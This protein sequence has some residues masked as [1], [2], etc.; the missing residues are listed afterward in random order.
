[1]AGATRTGGQLAGRDTLVRLVVSALRIGFAPTP[2]NVLHW[3]SWAITLAVLLGLTAVLL[4]GRVYGWEVDVA[5]W[6][7]K[8]DYPQWAFTL[9]ADRL[10]NSDTPEGA[11][12]IASVAAVL[13]FLRLRI[14]AA[15]I[16][17]SVPLHILGNFPKVLVVR[18]RPSEAIDG[19]TGLTG[20][21]SFPSGHAEF[22]ITFYGFLVYVA[23]LHVRNPTLKAALLA[24]WVAMVLAVGFARIEVG[25]H[26]PLD[27][28]AGY[29]V[30]VGLL[31]GLIWLH[32]SLY[33]AAEPA[34]QQPSGR[35]TVRT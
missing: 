22:A 16:A 14:E 12:I 8:V 23:L 25:E 5:R 17:L 31:S 9:T 29:V 3:A 32:R 30:G 13:W 11:A 4:D 35:Q 34:S 33:A 15:L 6:A 24:G 28:I 2:R 27:V 21:K 1:V 26:W 20:V 10:T 19:L 7:Q 18:D